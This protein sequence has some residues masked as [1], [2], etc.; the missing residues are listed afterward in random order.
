M[1]KLI[2]LILILSGLFIIALSIVFVKGSKEKQI[3][4]KEQ[5]LNNLRKNYTI[6]TSNYNI[7][8]SESVKKEIKLNFLNDLPNETVV[9]LYGTKSEYNI[10]INLAK[11][12][13]IIFSNSTSYDAVC[14]D[15]YVFISHSHPNTK[16]LCK[17]SKRD[18]YDLIDKKFKITGIICFRENPEIHIFDLY[19]KELKVEKL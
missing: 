15:D 16:K 10:S 13:E 7:S 5:E 6:E 19:A 12:A 8:L 14:Y 3:S 11:K 17:P 18:Y 2:L 9:C 4:E 1:R